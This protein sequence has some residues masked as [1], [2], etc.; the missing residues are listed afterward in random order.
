MSKPTRSSGSLTWPG[1]RADASL[2]SFVKLTG[3]GPE[4]SE[5]V[6]IACFGFMYSGSVIMR[7]S[8]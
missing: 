5:A 7:P 1:S 2:D 4:R 3:G 6:L 8:G